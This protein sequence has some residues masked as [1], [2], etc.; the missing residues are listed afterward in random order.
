M[1]WCCV[2]ISWP[3]G[4]GSRAKFCLRWGAAGLLLAVVA[5]FGN[6]TVTGEIRF[7]F[8]PISFTLENSETAMKYA[9][10]TMAGGLAV[11]DY[12]G[13]GDL[14][15]YFTNGA[16]MPGLVKSSPK[17]WNRLFANDGAGNFTDVTEGSGLAGSGYDTGV[18]VAD[19]DNDG[20]QDVFVGGV[21][22]RALY[23][24]DGDGSFTDVTA[25]AGLDKPDAKYGPLWSVGGAWLDADNDGRLDLFVVNYLSWAPDKEPECLQ[26]GRRD[27]CHPKYYKGTPN[28]FYLNNGDGTFSDASAAA[29]IRALVGKGMGAAVAD[30]DRDG[31][32]DIF[33]TNDKLA[34]FFFHNLGARR[35]EEI[36]LEVGVAWP[37]HGMDV[38]G[39]GADFRDVDNDG[40]PDIVFVA[41]EGETF[42]L[43]RNSGKGYFDED[44]ATSGMAKLSRAMSGYSPGIFDFDNDGWKD[45]F[46][47]R[48][49]VQSRV[50]QGTLEIDQHNSVFRNRARGRFVALTQKAGFASQ[51]PK[52][53]RGAAWGD[54]N[55]DG[56]VDAVVS[57]LGDRAEIWINNSPG[58]HHWLELDLEG[59]ASNRDGIGAT[60]K[61]V[62]KRGV[63]YNHMT[64]AVGYASSSAGP[65]HFGMGGDGRA[66]LLEIRWPS[67][68]VQRLENVKCDQVLKVKEPAAEPRTR[69][70]K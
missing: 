67:G 64:T 39:M 18:A 45:V 24:N 12:D 62:S 19:Y 20:D 34:N 36:A 59:S 26:N 37:E 48:G 69:A 10:E 2:T 7:V 68:R 58:G 46:V 55:G 70:G 66:D 56:R 65:V 47:S 50:L 57:A 30:F 16:E 42:P 11:F 3:D 40:L 35:F 33:V 43:F 52:R 51:P 22:H 29:G 14:D 5:A 49:H 23:R 4:F 1:G 6:E 61:L 53:H 38:S 32:P 25:A 21:H 63:Q 31:R 15:I 13:D 28:R 54:L 41:L 17:Y 9:P 44:T 8:H 27:Y 60:I